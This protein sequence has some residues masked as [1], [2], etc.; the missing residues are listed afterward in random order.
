M[1]YVRVQVAP[2]PIHGF[3]VF[4]LE[5]IAQGQ[6]VWQFTPGFDLDLDPALVENQPEPL[7]ERLLHY[8]YIDRW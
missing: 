6:V 2:S 3:G 4:T 1:L 5:N 8:G 7:R